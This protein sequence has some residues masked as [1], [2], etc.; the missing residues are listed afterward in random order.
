MA[1]TVAV[2][3]GIVS[4]PCLLSLIFVSDAVWWWMLMVLGTGGVLTSTSSAMQYRKLAAG[5]P[6][7]ATDDLKA[8][9]NLLVVQRARILIIWALL[10]VSAVLMFAG[11][12]TVIGKY[13]IVVTTVTIAT[14]LIPVIVFGFLLERALARE[15]PHCRTSGSVVFDGVVD[16]GEQVITTRTHETSTVHDRFNQYGPPIATIRTPVEKTRV[17][18]RQRRAFHCTACGHRWSK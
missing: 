7:T 2:F 10:I 15:C 14:L 13:S 18:R 11:V 1:I 8:A 5:S 6:N 12:A 17:Y 9:V 4:V 16:L 3:G